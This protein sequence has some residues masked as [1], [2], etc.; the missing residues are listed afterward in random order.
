LTEK[1][2]E[3]DVKN[4]TKNDAKM[5]RYKMIKMGGLKIDKFDVKM[6]PYK[7]IKN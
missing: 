6:T 4:Y 3:N 7:F 2:D 5:T 1:I